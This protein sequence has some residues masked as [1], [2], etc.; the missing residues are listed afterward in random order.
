MNTS[1]SAVAEVGRHSSGQESVLQRNYTID[2]N[3]DFSFFVFISINN[4]FSG[5]KTVSLIIYENLLN[6]NKLF[7]N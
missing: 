7:F 1:F 6:N 2:F 5:V 3:L 4:S